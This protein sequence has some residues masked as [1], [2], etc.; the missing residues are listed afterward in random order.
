MIASEIVAQA[1]RSNV[2]RHQP[3]PPSH[4]TVNCIKVQWKN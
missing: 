4:T 2:D 3:H 1:K